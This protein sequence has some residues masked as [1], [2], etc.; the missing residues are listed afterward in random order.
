LQGSFPIDNVDTSPTL[1]EFSYRTLV[2]GCR[3][4]TSYG[5]SGGFWRCALW[6]TLVAVSW[7]PS[8]L[9]S[10]PSRRLLFST[11]WRLFIDPIQECAASQPIGLRGGDVS[12]CAGESIAVARAQYTH[13][14]M[15]AASYAPCPRN[16]SALHCSALH[17]SALAVGPAPHVPPLG[18]TTVCLYRF[19]RFSA[20]SARFCSATALWLE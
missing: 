1:A 4:A 14:A 6:C 11:R 3:G 15:P 16:H 5:V 13:S 10:Q 18:Q 17:C 9:C 8:R 20:V 12:E 2:E 7:M 19:T